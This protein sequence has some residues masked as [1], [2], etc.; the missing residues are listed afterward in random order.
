MSFCIANDCR[1]ELKTGLSFFH[2]DM[3]PNPGSGW[4]PQKDRCRHITGMP[5]LGARGLHAWI[6][7][8]SC[9]FL[10]LQSTSRMESGQ[11]SP[12]I[13]VLTAQTEFRSS[14]GKKERKKRE[15]IYRSRSVELF[16]VGLLLFVFIY[17]V[18]FY[19]SV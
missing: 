9:S 11:E 13:S 4:L 19:F 2:T 5:I 8:T 17:F 7:K 14:L 10:R 12:C 15:K 3:P 6:H 18:F 16:S 1:C